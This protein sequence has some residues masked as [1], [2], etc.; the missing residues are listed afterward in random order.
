MSRPMAIAT[1]SDQPSVSNATLRHD[2]R[3][4]NLVVYKAHHLDKQV[5]KAGELVRQQGKKTGEQVK[6]KCC[7][8]Q[9]KAQAVVTRQA[10]GAV[11]SSRV[12]SALYICLCFTISSIHLSSAIIGPE[13]SLIN[14]TFVDPEQLQLCSWPLGQYASTTKFCHGYLSTSLNFNNFNLFFNS[15]TNTHFHQTIT[16]WHFTSC[17]EINITGYLTRSTPQK[18]HATWA[19]ADS[20]LEIA[21]P[22]LLLNL[23]SRSGS[24]NIL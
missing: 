12:S 11:F 18:Y 9:W 8:L 2:L 19:W 21:P 5:K 1:T 13:P 14:A 7:S 23:V 24:A 15:L 10:P 4:R 6:K 22:P 20:T 16:L 17:L 3:P